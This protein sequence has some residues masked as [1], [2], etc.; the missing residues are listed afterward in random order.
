[1]NPVTIKT[2][3]GAVRVATELGNPDAPVHVV[4]G[5]GLMA[6]SLFLT[7]DQACEI[8]NALTVARAMALLAAAEAKYEARWS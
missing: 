3:S 6:Q 8:L 4:L 7:T 5:Q 1:M 2:S